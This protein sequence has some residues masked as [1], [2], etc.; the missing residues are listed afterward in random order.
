MMKKKAD[1]VIKN[2]GML[3][4]PTGNQAKK[5]EEQGKPTVLYD[6]FIAVTDG[7]ISAVGTK[8]EL[9]DVET[10]EKTE[11]VDAGGK[12]VTPGLVDAHTHLVFGGWRQKELAQ[13]LRGVSYLEILRRGGGILS[14]VQSTR[15]ASY[16]ELLKKAEGILDKMLR[17]GTTTC[18]A[19]SGY[20]LDTDSEIKQM[21]AV[22]ELQLKRH[23]VDLVSTFLGAHAVPQE[24]KGNKKEYIKLICEEMLPQ[25]KEYKLAEFCDVFC[26]DSVFDLEESRTILEEGKRYGLV[27]KIHADEITP[28][29]GAALAAEV[30]AISADHL[31]K[32]TD[33]G[34]EAMAKAGTIA[35]LL[36][37]TSF[38][39]NESYARAKK[40][41]ELGVPVAVASDFNPGSSPN[42]S[43][44]LPMNLACLKYRM[45][46]E[47][48]LTA[49]TLNAA[50][51]LNRNWFI[52]SIENEKQA[53]IIIWDAPDLDYIF[54]HYGINQVKTV[55]K[56][57]KVVVSN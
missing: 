40:M 44:Q 1:V 13:K 57:G 37:A 6:A 3:V 53:D 16:E 29:G 28:L 10:D 46:P 42:L 49:V 36:P 25:V 34:L 30:E 4:T 18:E 26:E 19:K 47:E 8:N 33:E 22:R 55:I 24:Y 39:L 38:Y 31:I 20:G 35:V 5:G 54:Y 7:I 12:L 11:I 45:T 48:V 52:G 50:A 56:K 27:P 41:I 9:A 2:I 17:H 21:K 14:T 51:A 15:L 23:P 32:A 43:L